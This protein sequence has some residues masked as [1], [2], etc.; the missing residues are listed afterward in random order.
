M[1]AFLKSLRED[2]PGIRSMKISTSAATGKGVFEDI[3]PLARGE[4]NPSVQDN[5]NTDADDTEVAVAPRKL[6][7][8]VLATVDDKENIIVQNAFPASDVILHKGKKLSGAA[9]GL[10]K[11]Q[12]ITPTVEQG[13]RFGCSVVLFAFS[14]LHASAVCVVTAVVFNGLVVVVVV[15]VRL[16]ENAEEVAAALAAA[17]EVKQAKRLLAPRTWE[18]FEAHFQE[19]FDQFCEKWVNF[20]SVAE[21]KH[22]FKKLLSDNKMSIEKLRLGLAKYKVKSISFGENCADLEI[23]MEQEMQSNRELA[24]AVMEEK[25]AFQAKESALNEALTETKQEVERIAAE[26]KR[27]T[28]LVERSVSDLAG[29][30]DVL[31][32]TQ[33]ELKG[34]RET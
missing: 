30:E 18:A 17:N 23:A 26:E 27:L 22:D 24:A 16:E 33:S 31:E 19:P 2:A 15:V 21:G 25:A 10:C 34:L 6:R 13:T 8:R 9:A 12:K 4:R 14:L 20:V 28:L 11:K 3:A 1:A 5:K 7:K 29:V 32:E